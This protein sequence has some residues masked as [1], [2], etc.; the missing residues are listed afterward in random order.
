MERLF[1][2]HGVQLGV[3][4]GGDDAWH[5]RSGVCAKSLEAAPGVDCAHISNAREVSTRCTRCTACTR[6]GAALCMRARAASARD[7]RCGSCE[8]HTPV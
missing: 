7:A 1:D 5:V 6:G 4:G 2:R 8:S 3:V